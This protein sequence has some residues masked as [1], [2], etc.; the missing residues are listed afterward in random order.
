M[1]SSFAPSEQV[2]AQGQ[3]ASCNGL[4]LA[5]VPRPEPS[6]GPSRHIF[7]SFARRI[8]DHDFCEV[9]LLTDR[10]HFSRLT[11]C[12]MPLRRQISLLRLCALQKLLRCS[13]S[14][15]SAPSASPTQYQA[16]A[17]SRPSASWRSP[18][19][20]RAAMFDQI[21]C[22]LVGCACM[23]RQRGVAQPA[24]GVRLFPQ[25]GGRQISGT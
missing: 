25:A 5:G 21:P 3:H 14:V 23:G 2:N 24:A 9:A 11:Q 20:V 7:A 22:C 18:R 6:Q 16:C 12:C 4:C 15:V 8:F 13:H 19:V 17:S 10:R 1:T